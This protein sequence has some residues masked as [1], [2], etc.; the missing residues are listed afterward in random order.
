MQVKAPPVGIKVSKGDGET[1]YSNASGYGHLDDLPPCL[2]P[3]SHLLT[4]VGVHQQVVQ[5]QIALISLLDVIQE[6][7]PNNA[8]TLR[9]AQRAAMSVNLGTTKSP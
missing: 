8:A 5:V 9:P 4:K 1:R 3:L 6:A 7:C 2:L